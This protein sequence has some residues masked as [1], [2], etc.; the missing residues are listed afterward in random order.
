MQVR[1]KWL[2]EG[3]E[4]WKAE[5]I[6]FFFSLITVFTVIMQESLLRGIIY[7]IFSKYSNSSWKQCSH[8]KVS[9]CVITK[10][11]LLSVLIINRVLGLMGAELL[12]M[13]F[14]W[15]QF[16]TIFHPKP[17][18]IESIQEGLVSKLL[19]CF[20]NCLGDSIIM[21]LSRTLHLGGNLS[22]PFNPPESMVCLGACRSRWFS[23]SLKRRK[24]ASGLIS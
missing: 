1:E 10:P 5:C 3:R 21:G 16:Y 7:L 24:W 17:I 9:L 22:S 20:K 12:C 4:W 18:G 23:S 2:P 6:W 13:H 15:G 14:T 19:H 11:R 8:S